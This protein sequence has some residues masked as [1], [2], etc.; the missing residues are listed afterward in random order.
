MSNSATKNTKATA[1]AQASAEAA[2]RIIDAL[3]SGQPVSLADAKILEAA[4]CYVRRN[5][6]SA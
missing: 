1:H 2:S 5:V 6:V 4:G 3:A